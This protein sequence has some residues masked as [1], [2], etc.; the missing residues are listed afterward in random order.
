MFFFKSF[1]S[2]RLI[3]LGIL[4]FSCKYAESQNFEASKA[5]FSQDRY[6]DYSPAYFRGGLVFCST[7]LPDITT[8]QA[9][10]DQMEDANIWYVPMKE[11][12][13]A[14]AD[15]KL[16]EGLFTRFNDGPATFS[17]DGLEIYYSRN[18][19]VDSRKRD[20]FDSRNQLGLFSARWID[21][22]W[23]DITPFPYNSTKYSLTTPALSPDGKRIY[24]ASDMPGGYGGADLW[25]CDR[26][27]EGW[28]P[29]VNLGSHINTKGNESYPFENGAG[30]LYFASDGL[31]GFGKKDIFFTRELN[32]D[33][34]IPVHMNAHINSSE[35]DFGLITDLNGN[36]GYFSSNRQNK[37]DIYHFVTKFPQFYHCDSMQ[38]NFYCYAF[39]DESSMKIDSLPLSYM[40]YFSDGESAGGLEVEHC[41]AGTGNYL[42]E[43]H[44]ID[45]N[46]GNTFF[47]Q[48][49]FEV[50]LTDVEQPYIASPDA[51]VSEELAGFDGLSTN[52]PQLEVEEY[53]W[54]FADGTRLRGAEVEH[55]FSGKGRYRVQLM[56]IGKPDSTGWKARECVYKVVEVLQD[57][58]DL[59]MYKA[60]QEG[61]LIIMQDS[62][63]KDAFVS[64]SY[65]SLEEAQ[66]QDA[67]FRVEVLNSDSRIS[68]D[69][70]VFDP[71]RGVYDI[72]EVFL[73]DDSLYSYT[74]GQSDDVLGTYDVYADV[75]ER[76]FE[77]ASVKSY[78]LADLAEEELLQLTSALGNFSDAYFEFDDYRIGE[79][80]YPILNEVVNIMNRYPSLQLEIAA[81]TDNMGSFEYNMTLSQ[82]RAQSMVDY[83]V[84]HG[85]EAERLIGKGYG[86]SRPIASNT[87]EEG[88]ML[89]RRVEF[90][91]LDER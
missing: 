1:S 69:S 55:A 90:I 34:A 79:A 58:Q 64:N 75:V 52:L 35:D 76:G 49:S 84:D 22:T 15:P 42:V 70:S 11:S 41:F 67:V 38:K 44:I 48:S 74:V 33:W 28:L 6:N 80:S 45:N 89:N 46:T 56:V 65:Y 31:K 87:S 12:T 25:Y 24:F 51:L 71:L 53:Y 5:S 62:T 85:I 57:H 23:F 3:V 17:S 8:Y 32:G 19:D 50:E 81:H 88:K 4:L 29:P 66:E 82:R 43:L 14:E 63:D 59:A 54:E 18:L 21:T 40:W 16:L 72:R 83:L 20:I 61:S 47:T 10:P 78:I 36:E 91:I 2:L 77:N 13:V 27:E 37:D 60:R 68:T 86:E 7:R 9:S 26:S 73:R 39:Y 30:I